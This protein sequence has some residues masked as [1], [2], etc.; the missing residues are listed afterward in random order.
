MK[1]QCLLTATHRATADSLDPPTCPVASNPTHTDNSAPVTAPEQVMSLEQ[2]SASH[3]S[4]PGIATTAA[5]TATQQCPAPLLVEHLGK[6]FGTTDV[7][8]RADYPVFTCMCG[9]SCD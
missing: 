4:G 8:R 2:N 6:C 5:A 9:G 7:V 1:V 3:F